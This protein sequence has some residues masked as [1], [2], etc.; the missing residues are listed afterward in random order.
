M[1]LTLSSNNPLNTTLSDNSSKPIY[2]IYTP[3]K[4]FWNS[5]RSSTSIFKVLDSNTD[6]SVAADAVTH[7]QAHELSGDEEENNV[8][9]QCDPISPSLVEVARIRWHTWATSKIIYQGRL[10]PLKTW[11][12]NTS[13]TGRHRRFTGPGGHVYEWNLG[14]YSCK[15][16]RIDGNGPPELIA[17][18]HQQK[19]LE[20]AKA[21]LEIRP[22]GM[23][24][25]E[26]IVITWVFIETR[27]RDKE[28]QYIFTET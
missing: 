13:W 16:Q 27:R 26:L 2:Q 11:L 4:H 8:E 5:A 1:D 9:L 20:H 7:D 14:Y 17:S 21:H 3:K 22:A 28:R 15:L 24:I 12:P 23:D 10:Y 25:F 18:F 6:V 19:V